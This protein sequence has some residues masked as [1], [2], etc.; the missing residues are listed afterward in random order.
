MTGSQ[1]SNLNSMKQVIYVY[2]NY[3]HTL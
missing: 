3:S 2:N 1:E